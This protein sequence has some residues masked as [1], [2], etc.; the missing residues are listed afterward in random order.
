MLQIFIASRIPKYL[1]YFE[2]V[3]ERNP[4]GDR[5]LVGRRVSYCDLSLFQ[6][7]AGLRYAFPLAV[8][9]LEPRLSRITVCTAALLPA[10]A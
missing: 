4:Q 8:A 7:I 1:A 6:L 3:L 10:R 5:H 9:R 2:R